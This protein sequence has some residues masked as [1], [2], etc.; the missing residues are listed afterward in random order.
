MRAFAVLGLVGLLAVSGLLPLAT[1][2]APGP[3]PGAG[4]PP[5]CSS[6]LS[7]TVSQYAG[8]APLTIDFELTS[9]W[10]VPTYESW[11]FEP[12]AYANGSGAAFLTP[13]YQY[14]A[15][16][17]Y[18]AV[19]SVQASQRSGACTVGIEI[20]PPALSVAANVDQRSGLAPLAVHFV[21]L[22]SGGTGVFDS[23]SWSFGDGHAAPGWNLTHTYTVPGV[24]RADFEVIDSS[25]ALANASVTI[26]VLANLPSASSSDLSLG[27]L[28]IFGAI[29]LG[30]VGFA[31]GA[32]YV[33]A[34]GQRRARRG[35]PP[36]RDDA[37]DPNGQGPEPA[38]RTATE[39]PDAP[40]SAA[41]E[42]YRGAA[43]G[44]PVFPPQ[45][46]RGMMLDLS[47][48]EFEVL[49]H[50][51]ARTRPAPEAVEREIAPA[52][53]VP[54]KPQAQLIARPRLSHRVMLH[55][56]QLPRLGPDD[57]PTAAFTQAGMTELLD[58]QQSPLSNVLRRLTYSGL[59][60]HEVRHV[61][62][63]SRRMNV[64]RLTPKGENWVSRLRKEREAAA[65]RERPTLPR[66]ER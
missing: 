4:S 33:R 62:G 15:V 50:P 53:P 40:V 10:G 3:V 43:D 22:I 32:W 19:V 56:G 24:Y 66:P 57:T 48:L 6:G 14:R 54:S 9:Y 17:S 60:Q 36:S 26:E 7:L 1:A 39:G 64:Y 37:P 30:V 21:G 27:S 38:P 31:G 46:Y 2:A 29:G 51:T 23:V 5:R 58:V 8:P 13:T 34:N 28:S 55:L 12:G 59:I 42:P 20:T 45:M 18:E 65:L 49:E 47:E 35:P 16:G 25:G 52:A 44:G 41:I 11:Q 63:A 61:Q